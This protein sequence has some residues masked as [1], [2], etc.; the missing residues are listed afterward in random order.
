MSY[1]CSFS[2]FT[3]FSPSDVILLPSFLKNSSQ[4]SWIPLQ[5]SA[6]SSSSSSSSSLQWSDYNYIQLHSSK[7]T[8]FHPRT[9]IPISTNISIIL[10]KS[11]NYYFT[12][13]PNQLIIN[14]LQPPPRTL[15]FQFQIF[16]KQYPTFWNVG[17]NGSGG[18]Q[19]KFSCRK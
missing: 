7:I 10:S 6:S 13:S 9:S 11:L 14:S 2:P 4:K 3:F 19:K 5:S 18:G 15:H 8:Q 1:C 12:K 16:N 17:I